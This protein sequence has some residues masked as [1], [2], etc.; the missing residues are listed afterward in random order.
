MDLALVQNEIQEILDQSKQIADQNNLNQISDVKKTLI[1]D[2]TNLLKKTVMIKNLL[3]N[4]K[5]I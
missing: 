3:K 4:F 1:N 2:Q 5:I